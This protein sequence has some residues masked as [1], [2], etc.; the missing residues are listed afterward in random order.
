MDYLWSPWRYRYV[1]QAGENGRCLFCDKAS[2]DP[3]HDPDELVLYRGRLNF[4]LLN[5]FPYT[6]GHVMVAPYEHTGRLDKVA[7]E[8]L[9]EM[10]ELAQRIHAALQEI[11]HP[12]GFNLGMNLGK[13]AGAG[14][15]D[16]LHLH[17]LPRWTGDSG[18]MTVIGETRVSPEDLSAT[19]AKLL[20]FFAH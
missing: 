19:Y 3:S 4:I 6:N 12:E 11:Y 18:F 20:P 16:H 8:T 13:C 14:V 2:L 1:S 17:F 7:P 5:L 15:A 10:M 9:A